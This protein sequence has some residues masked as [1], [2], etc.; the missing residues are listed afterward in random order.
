LTLSATFPTF[1]RSLFRENNPVISGAA[2]FLNP[3]I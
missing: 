2:A 1:A 3:L